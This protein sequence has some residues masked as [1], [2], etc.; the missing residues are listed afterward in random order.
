MKVLHIVGILLLMYIPAAAQNINDLSFGTDSTLEIMTWN[1]E[2]FP[3]KGTTT[4]NYVKQII[5]ALDVDIIAFQEVADTTAFKNMMNSMSGYSYK[6]G[7]YYYTTLAFAYKTDVIQANHLYDIYNS[8]AYWSTFPRTPIVMN[9]NYGDE[10]IF[11]IDNHLKCCGDGVLDESDTNDEEYRRYLA[12]NLLKEYI[13]GHFPNNKV[14]VVGDMN[15]ELTDETSNNIFRNII[16]DNQ[17]F[18]FTD[19]EIAQGSSSG[20]SYPS[21]PSHLDHILITN[22]LFA[23][24]ENYGSSIEVIKVDNYVGGWNTYDNNISD[25]RPVGLKLN[26]NNSSNAINSVYSEPQFSVFPNPAKTTLNIKFDN[27][28]TSVKIYNIL[29]NC[30][31]SVDVKNNTSPTQINVDDLPNGIYFATALNGNK[32]IGHRKFVVIR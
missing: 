21:W 18:L 13:E 5:T 22:E 14:V 31:D 29:G 11:L 6:L 26:F 25:H 30:V 7:R 27:N 24:F 1:I 23:D 12:C 3:K 15:D 9:F 20:W 4:S 32:T 17:N 2:N 16:A 8:S 28:C 19:M 10:Q